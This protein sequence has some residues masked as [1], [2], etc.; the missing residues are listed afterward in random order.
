[1]PPASCLQT[2]I[3]ARLLAVTVSLVAGVRVG[4]LGAEGVG[5]ALV[6]GIGLPVDAVEG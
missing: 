1:V 3:S 6:G 4:V 5:G 2:A